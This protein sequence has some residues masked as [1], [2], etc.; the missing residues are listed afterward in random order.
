MWQ[1]VH[2]E[3]PD[4]YVL[5][6]GEAHSVREFVER[7]FAEV[8]RAITWVDKGVDEKGIDAKTGQVLVEVDSRYFRPTEVDF[9]LGDPSKAHARLGWRRT[10]TFHELVQEMVAADLVTMK[11]EGQERQVRE[12]AE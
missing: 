8:G 11:R 7:A 3:Q 10:T 9:L 1:V 4:D 5:A 6:T 2:Q 12:A